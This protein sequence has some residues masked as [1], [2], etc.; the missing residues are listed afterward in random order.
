MVGGYAMIDCTGLNLVGE[1][2]NIPAIYQ[3]LTEQN[4]KKNKPVLL[5]NLENDGEL[6]TPT[7]SRLSVGLGG[8]RDLA[9]DGYVIS[10]EADGDIT[11]TESGGGSVDPSDVFTMVD[12]TDIS[13]VSTGTGTADFFNAVKAAVTAGKPIFIDKLEVSASDP[14]VTPVPAS[15]AYISHYDILRGIIGNKSVILSGASDDYAITIS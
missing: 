9:I 11:V 8:T 5:Y 2:L 14:A 12:G 10:V 4:A 6:L 13:I 7:W 1:N 15:F 3:Q